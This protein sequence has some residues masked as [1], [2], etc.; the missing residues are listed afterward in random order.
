[1]HNAHI[2]KSIQVIILALQ[3]EWVS[4]EE[5]LTVDCFQRNLH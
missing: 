4:T 5:C 2:S 1:M 3:H